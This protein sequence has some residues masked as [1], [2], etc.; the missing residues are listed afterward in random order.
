MNELEE[1][2]I[3]IPKKRHSIRGMIA[4]ALFA[5]LAAVLANLDYLWFWVGFATTCILI[6]MIDPII[7]EFNL[8]KKQKMYVFISYFI[9]G[10]T[11]AYFLLL[12]LV[13]VIKMYLR[14]N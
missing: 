2:K 1:G 4:G 12:V 8:S 10:F 13:L 9:F 11:L 6:Y 5:A 7:P 3:S 14:Q